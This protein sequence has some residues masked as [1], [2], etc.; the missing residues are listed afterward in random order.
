MLYVYFLSHFE[1][2]FHLFLGDMKNFDMN[3][4][5]F[6]DDVFLR[7]IHVY[8]YHTDYNNNEKVYTHYIIVWIYY[9]CIFHME[10]YNLFLKYFLDL[11]C[12]HF[13]SS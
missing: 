2:F 1:Y 12:H 10:Y 13:D 11:K 4:L 7:V 9:S 5:I 6:F 8:W 3:Q